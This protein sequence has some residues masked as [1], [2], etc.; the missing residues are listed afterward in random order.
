M[1]ITII[2]E[3]QYVEEARERV[4]TTFKNISTLKIPLSPTGQTPATH[5]MCSLDVTEEGFKKLTNLKKHSIMKNCAASV[6]LKEMDL[7][8]IK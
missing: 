3:D 1:K 5:W 4:K 7:K 8:L 2:I 6:L